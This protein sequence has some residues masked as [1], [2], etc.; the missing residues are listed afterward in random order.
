MSKTN[1]IPKKALEHA[2]QQDA[3]RIPM[4]DLRCGGCL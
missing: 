3:E 1:Q 2:E 4:S